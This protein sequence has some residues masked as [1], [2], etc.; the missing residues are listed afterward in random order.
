ME[1]F[2]IAI[3]VMCG[4]PEGVGNSDGCAWYRMQN[5]PFDTLEECRAALPG[6]DAGLVAMLDAD[7]RANSQGFTCAPVPYTPPAKGNP[8]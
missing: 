7:M 6:L 8:T 2:W 4:A 1:V 3:S 5:A